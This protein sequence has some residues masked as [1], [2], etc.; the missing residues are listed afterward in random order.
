MYKLLIKTISSFVEE[1]IKKK[2]DVQFL[3]LF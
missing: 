2:K 1:H 3:L